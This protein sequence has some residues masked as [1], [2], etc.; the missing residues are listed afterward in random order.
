MANALNSSVTTTTVDRNIDKNS[1]QNSRLLNNS[2]TAALSESANRI[3]QDSHN[4]QIMLK[5]GHQAKN[6][7][8]C[9]VAT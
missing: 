2:Q 5:I 8:W 9:Q 1:M 7:R 4:A 3:M 6:L